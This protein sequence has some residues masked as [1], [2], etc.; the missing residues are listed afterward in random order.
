MNILVTFGIITL[1]I[2]TIAGLGYLETVNAGKDKHF[3]YDQVGDGHMCY[4]KDK[5]C[6]K[7]QKNDE[8]AESPCY[9][10]DRT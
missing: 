3:C 5:H 9:N 6:E 4:A 8:I 1:I 10:Q 2:T 7:D